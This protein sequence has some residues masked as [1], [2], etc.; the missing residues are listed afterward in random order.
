MKNFIETFNYGN[1]SSANNR[2]SNIVATNRF[3]TRVPNASQIQAEFDSWKD[4]QQEL[5]Y[6]NEREIILARET[7]NARARKSTI[8]SLGDIAEEETA[9]LGCAQERNVGSNTCTVAIDQGE[10]VSSSST[11][12][13]VDSDRRFER[14][15]ESV[16]IYRKLAQPFEVS[17]S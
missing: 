7:V 6:S 9:L 3:Q 8:I 13:K 4:S 1:K 11:F 2:Y 10:N 17:V 14:K 12:G 5:S 16:C 15:I